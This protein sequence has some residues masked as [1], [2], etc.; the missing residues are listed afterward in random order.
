ME[1]DGDYQGLIRSRYDANRKRHIT[2]DLENKAGARLRIIVD[3]RGCKRAEVK[4]QAVGRKGAEK[5]V[6]REERSCK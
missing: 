5:K 1:T 3:R 2:G 4:E 6:R